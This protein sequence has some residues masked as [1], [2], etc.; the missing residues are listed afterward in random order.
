MSTIKRKFK[1]E[2]MHCNSC[3][4]LIDGD[5]ED[6]DGIKSANTNFA[7][8]ETEVEFDPD[9][10]SDSQILETVQKSGYTAKPL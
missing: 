1:I 2:G 3:T 4:M 6:L 5:L 8:S 10:T 9:K 7:K